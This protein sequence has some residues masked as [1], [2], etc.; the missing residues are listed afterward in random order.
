[1]LSEAAERSE[2]APIPM[3]FQGLRH[4]S[5]SREGQATRLVSR[6]ALT[7]EFLRGFGDVCVDF[8]AQLLFTSGVAAKETEQACE[9]DSQGGHD[10]SS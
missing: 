6:N 2:S 5:E 4:A 1:M 7:L 8:G 10:R 3:G 9:K